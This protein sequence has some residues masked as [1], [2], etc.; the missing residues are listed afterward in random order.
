VPVGR[1]RLIEGETLINYRLNAARRYRAGHRLKHLHRADRDI[2]CFD[3]G[4]VVFKSKL[5]YRGLTMSR[6]AAGRVQA[7]RL[8]S[9]VREPLGAPMCSPALIAIRALPD[10]YLGN[11]KA[12]AW[13]VL[14]PDQQE[15][16][17]LP[18]SLGLRP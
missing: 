2:R 3:G 16:R 17:S 14:A 7:A 4:A 15:V 18:R 6:K 1:L 11:P 12:I 9:P 5:A 10:L 8:T 13:L